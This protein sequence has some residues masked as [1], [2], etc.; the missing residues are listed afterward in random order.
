MRFQFYTPRAMQALSLSRLIDWL[1]L[2]NDVPILPFWESQT[3][4]L[5]AAKSAFKPLTL[6]QGAP[7]SHDWLLGKVGMALGWRG[8]CVHSSASNSII[9]SIGLIQK[10]WA[11]PSLSL[12]VNVK[13]LC[14]AQL[15]SQ[16][17]NIT[18]IAFLTPYCIEIEHQ[19]PLRFWIDDIEFGSGFRAQA[20]RSCPWQL[21]YSE[22]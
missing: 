11:D 7:V 5:M 4:D 21:S 6:S 3:S 14:L 13:S 15:L 8:H 18:S 12:Q 2:L 10:G 22:I 20:R 19:L 1:S 17:Y 9:K 16:W